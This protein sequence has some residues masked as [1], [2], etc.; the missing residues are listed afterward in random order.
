MRHEQ[1]PD[2]SLKRLAVRRDVRWIYSRDNHASRRFLRRE[3]AVAS[4]N[5]DH[6]RANF[7]GKLNRADE[8]RADVFF[9]GLPPPTEKITG[10]L[11]N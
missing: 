5:A 10:R 2:D 3:S 6:R 8:I 11:L 4:D 1:M 9:P 7:F